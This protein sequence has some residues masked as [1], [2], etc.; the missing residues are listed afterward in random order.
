MP[1]I[2]VTPSAHPLW[3]AA[4]IFRK[5]ILA[6][7]VQHMK[8]YGE[9]YEIPLPI[10]TIISIH[11]AEY[12]KHVLVSN[13]KNYI[14]D[15]PT[16]RL[17]LALGNGLLTSE[18]EFWRRQ[19]RIA[20]PAFHRERLAAMAQSMVNRTTEMI[21]VWEKG[22]ATLDISREMMVLT[23][24]IAAQTLFGADV[25][26]NDRFG[27]ALVEG[28]RYITQSFRRIINPPLWVPTSAN[29]RFN[30]MIRQQ[31]QTIQT[32]IDQ[33]RQSTESRPDLLSMLMEARD[34]ESGEGMTD[35]QLR[36]EVITI[37]SAGHETSA[38][39][40]TW[41]LYLLSQNPDIRTRMEREV[42]EVLQG[43][44]PQVDDVRRL[45]YVHQVIQESLRLFPPAWAIGREA[46]GPDEIDGYPI[47]KKYQIL[48]SSY[49][50][51]RNPRYWQEPDR[52]EPDRFSP[53]KVKE[54]HRFAY[55][56]FGGGPRFCIGN[57]FALMEM[58]LV[59]VMISQRFRIDL[60]PDHPVKMEP[61]I[62]LRPMYGMK[63]RLT[64][65]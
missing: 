40:L 33:R 18:G 56:P 44:L 3:G 43:R 60:V 29:R 39:G 32:M 5:D 61:V 21:E 55:L 46:I 35:L 2:P 8:E 12:I 62:T 25:D 30:K 24:D 28:M 57:N 53:E 64:N 15:I 45:P 4:P 34:E 9:I 59:L 50:L 48:M 27:E 14:K 20:Q 37:F 42:D 54:R 13:N 58:Q 41:T 19:R 23:S 11:N 6:Y 1:K 51:H 38:N 65:R 49:A 52:F 10:R 36:D 16:R 26:D 47:R 7:L 31:N 22:A 17:S 63:M